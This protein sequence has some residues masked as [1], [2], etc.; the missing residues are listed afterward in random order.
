MEIK[1]RCYK[2]W[3]AFAGQEDL[4]QISVLFLLLSLSVFRF[5]DSFGASSFPSA[6]RLSP[7]IGPSVSPTK[8]MFIVIL[9][10]S[11]YYGRHACRTTTSRCCLPKQY[12]V[13]FHP[14]QHQHAHNVFLCFKIV[15]T[16]KFFK[17]SHASLTL[18]SA[19]PSKI[20]DIFKL[21]LRRLVYEIYIKIYRKQDYFN[22]FVWVN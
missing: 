22:H 18:I 7:N 11:C 17:V 15:S 14:Y 21:P 2:S 8:R 1:D 13:W 16:I 5:L 4:T 3:P 9:D 6:T 20:I 12:L 19:H 10:E